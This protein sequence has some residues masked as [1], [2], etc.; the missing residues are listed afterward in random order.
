MDTIPANVNKE[1]ESLD[2]SNNCFDCSKKKGSK[3][4]QNKI[5][6]LTHYCMSY[7]EYN[8]ELDNLQK[9]TNNLHKKKLN[10]IL[11][12][13]ELSINKRY[14][15]LDWIM[16]LSSKLYFQRK[17]YCICSNIIDMYFSRT[18]YKIR[19]DEIQLVGVTSLIIAA[20]FEECILPDLDLFIMAC[21]NIY[22]KKE[23]IESEI[24]ITMELNWDIKYSCM[25]DWGNLLT[26]T[27]DINVEKFEQI[28]K[29]KKNEYPRFYDSSKN[30]NFL[31]SFQ[32]I[33]DFITLDYEYNFMDE[34]YIC[35]NIIFLLVGFAN[36]I[37]RIDTINKLIENYNIKNKKI[38]SLR[39]DLIEIFSE[40]CI[41]MEL[42]DQHLE[43]CYK[44]F[45][46]KFEKITYKNKMDEN[47]FILLQKHNPSFLRHIQKISEI[48]AKK[49]NEH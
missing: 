38:I 30:N 24:K 9:I 46:I 5:N 29:I 17:T 28:G 25:Y 10:Y 6:N 34:K 33:I 41:N 40:I 36:N 48:E 15:L 47:D 13:P 32:Q 18:R 8:N 37:F 14:I 2:N 26:Y 49:M 12:Q 45:N 4:K 20:K 22:T 3:F 7:E 19:T 27:W 23:I 44:F 11:K 39:K 42:L 1:E 35:I 21:D 43:Y 16:Y 31:G